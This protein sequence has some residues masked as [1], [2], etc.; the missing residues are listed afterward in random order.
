MYHVG[1]RGGGREGGLEAE[2]VVLGALL[3]GGGKHVIGDL[4]LLV[5]G[6]CVL[7][8][9]LLSSKVGLE[10]RHGLLIDVL[11]LVLLQFVDLGHS[12]SLLDVVR[13]PAVVNNK[14]LNK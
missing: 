11:V 14:I 12:S 13:I 4:V 5:V 6:G 1:G 8:L 3:S 9:F 2:R 10:E 7:L